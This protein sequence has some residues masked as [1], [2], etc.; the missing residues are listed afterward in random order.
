MGVKRI[1]SPTYIQLRLLVGYLGEKN[2]LGWWAT[3]FLSPVAKAF[4]EPSFP[5]TWRVAQYTAAT[6]A[7]RRVHDEHI[8][9]GNVFHLFRLPEELERQLHTHMLANPGDEKPFASL[10]ARD[11]AMQALDEFASGTNTSKEGPINIGKLS[12]IRELDAFR[13]IAR[14]YRDAF[15]RGSK[16]FPYFAGNE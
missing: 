12:H 10:A 6:E 9:V 16:V 8:G 1:D 5:R 7:A 2:Q 14:H 3:D 11:S 15:E 4:L 13:L